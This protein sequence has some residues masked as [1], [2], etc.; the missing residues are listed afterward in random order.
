MDPVFN[1]ARKKVKRAMEQLEKP[2]MVGLG[3]SIRLDLQAKEHL[4]S[5]SVTTDG[6]QR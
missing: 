4:Y 3:P 6:R 1:S 2:R 5:T